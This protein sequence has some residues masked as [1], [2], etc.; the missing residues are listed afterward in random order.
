MEQKARRGELFLTVAVGYVKAGDDLIEK[1]ADRRVQEAIALV[2]RKFASGEPL[3]A[4]MS[5]QEVRQQTTTEQSE[6]LAASPGRSCH[7]EQTGGRPTDARGSG[8][9]GLAPFPVLDIRVDA[10]RCSGRNLHG[11]SS[12]G[13]AKRH[14]WARFMRSPAGRRHCQT[15]RH[16][17]PLWRIS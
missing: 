7:G 15:R 17:A 4:L 2:F 1:D 13:S 16:R 12:Q 10:R 11:R 14:A 9:A 3:R 5:R 8:Q 6:A